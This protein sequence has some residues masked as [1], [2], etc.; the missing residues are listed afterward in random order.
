MGQQQT[1]N[2]Q[3]GGGVAMTTTQNQRNVKSAQNQFKAQQWQLD[4]LEKFKQQK[5]KAAA[6]AA[7]KNEETQGDGVKSTGTKP[8]TALS[9]LSTKK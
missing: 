1:S 3:Y 8:T 9:V 4:K 7:A 2:G 6:A 5:A